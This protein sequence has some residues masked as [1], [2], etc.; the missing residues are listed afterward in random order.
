MLWNKEQILLNIMTMVSIA[1]CSERGKALF[2]FLIAPL[3]LSNIIAVPMEKS[4]I[5]IELL[6]SHSVDAML[7][8][9]MLLMMM[10]SI[11]STL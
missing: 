8:I 3:W 4:E 6:F 2:L 9:L 5:P 10:V 11:A 1:Q 7:T